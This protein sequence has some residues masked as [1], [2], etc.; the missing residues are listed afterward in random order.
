MQASP[1]TPVIQV[2]ECAG[3]Q[4]AKGLDE[5]EYRREGGLIICQV[6]YYQTV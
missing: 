6:N 2:H 1:G 5:G 4:S 3:A